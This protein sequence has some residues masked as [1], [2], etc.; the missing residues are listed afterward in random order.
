MYL[1]EYQMLILTLGH[2]FYS[3]HSSKSRRKHQRKKYS[4]KEGSKF[5]DFALLEALAGIVNSADQLQCR[6]F[7][8]K[9]FLQYCFIIG[10]FCSNETVF[11]VCFSDFHK[12]CSHRRDNSFET[13]A[14][15]CL[16]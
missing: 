2:C 6:H 11:G 16:V 14:F 9:I 8:I 15:V 10:A 4:L 12:S 7:C 13:I 3:R 1:E 5:E